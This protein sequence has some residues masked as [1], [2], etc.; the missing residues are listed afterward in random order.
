MRHSIYT[1]ERFLML[2]KK[3]M[4]G[5]IL[6][7]FLFCLNTTFL[8][9]QDDGSNPSIK[10]SE[11]GSS[12]PIVP[13]VAVGPEP[14]NAR[15]INTEEL[16]A[17]IQEAENAESAFGA[18]E[19]AIQQCKAFEDYEKMISQI[20]KLAS[21]KDY[22]FQD[23]LD[24]A[25]G[26]ARVE[27]LFFLTKKN[28]IE[29][30]RIYMSVNEKYYNE[31]LEYLDKAGKVTKSKDLD[32]GIYFLKFIIFKEIFQPQKVDGVFNEMV[33]KI[34][35]Y[36]EESSKNLA[37]L[38]EISGKLSDNG[39]SDDAMK[40]KLIYASK[41][42][43][44]SAK[45]IADEIK[46]DADKYF[47]AGSAKEAIS[48]YDT[49]LQLAENYYD[50]DTMSA[51]LMDIAEKYFNNS[52][53]K[54]AIKYYSLYLFK[55]G[56]SQVA[57]YASSKLAMSYSYDKDYAKAVSKFEEFLNTYPNSVWF[58]KGF[59]SLCRLYYE[60]SKL[61]KAQEF[62]Q[63]LIDTYPRRETRDYAYLLNG[64]LYYSKADYDKALEIFKKIQQS[65]PKSAY[66]YATDVLITDINDIKK[67]GN[68]SY[69]FGSKDVYKVWDVYAQI[70]ADIGLGGGAQVIESKDA[71]P[72][73]IFIKTKA[74]SKVTFTIN[75]LEDLD[76]F[77][78]YWQDKEDQSRLPREIKTETEKDLVFLIWSGTDGGKFLDDK[79]TLSRTWRAPDESGNCVITINIGDLG[80]VRPPDTG[81]RKDTSKTLAIHVFVE[82]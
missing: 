48:T 14:A 62:L 41:V 72:G 44:N 53:Y 13:P 40:L 19:S 2:L 36:S 64:I 1:Q 34:G 46:T 5:L 76:R 23:V 3:K 67:G 8:F 52:Q 68:P 21:M 35:S 11:T 56:A 47:D 69:S 24:Y 4:A 10:G 63:K 38:N 75:G 50:K 16:I 29:S 77:H 37:K 6:A 80:L 12:E 79:Q 78:E 25:V 59:E 70:S 7:A 60:N 18:C 74:G 81:S 32:L 58:E 45:R 31:A 28:D 73:E 65:F 66:L 51:R 61:E 22:A 54:Y 27:E 20:K 43:P 26:K 42:D 71:K 39:M 33:N 30:G 49:Y 17:N 57:D 82:K 55:Y 9:S 15:P